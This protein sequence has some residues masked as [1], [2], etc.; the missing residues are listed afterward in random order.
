MTSVAVALNSLNYEEASAWADSA[1]RQFPKDKLAYYCRTE[2]YTTLA[3][4]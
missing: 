2:I 3:S 1:A 4:Y